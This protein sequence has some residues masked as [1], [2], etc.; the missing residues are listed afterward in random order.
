M[1]ADMGLFSQ[2]DD[3]KAVLGNIQN[4]AGFRRTRLQALGKLTDFTGFSIEMDFATAGRPSFMDVWGE[5]SE[6]PFFGTIRIGQFRQPITMDGWTS[7]RHLDFLERNA[8]FQGMDPFRRIGIMAYNTTEDERTEWAYSIYGTAL[9]FWNGASTVIANEGADNRYATQLTDHGGVSTAIR[10]SHLLF[11]DEPSEGR[12]LL[13]I[14]GGYNFSQLGGNPNSIGTDANAYDARPIPEIF[15]GDFTGFPLT[16]A[17]TPAVLDTG[18]IRARNY[19]L[20]HTEIAMNYGS[21][22]FQNEWM[23]TT[24]NQT[25]GPTI[26]MPGTYAQCGYFLT[27]ESSAYNKQAGVMDYNVVP[28]SDFFGLGRGRGIG[29]WGA[30]E[31]VARWTYYDLT[32]NN[33]AFITTA[34]NTF[35]PSPNLGVLNESTLGLNWWWNRFTRVQFNWIHSMP[36]YQV[37]PTGFPGPVGGSPFDVFATRFQVEF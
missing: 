6:L 22:H 33:A 5:Q 12:Y 31:V 32:C 19:N 9:S 11:Y 8:V 24:L 34:P 7:I 27:G 15:I 37:T 20:W 25:N 14:G 23:L 26:W 28:Y 17:G 36:N 4:G 3:S 1:Q 13:H 35:P 30:W 10:A 18:R 29:G 16:A 2:S 21:F